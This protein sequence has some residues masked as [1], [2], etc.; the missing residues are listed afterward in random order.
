MKVLSLT[1]VQECE[2][3]V[4]SLTRYY[5]TVRLGLQAA[6]RH[7]PVNQVEPL[8]E[9]TGAAGVIVFG[10]AWGMCGRFNDQLAAY[11]AEQLG[12]EALAPRRLLALGEYIGE[13]LAAHDRPADSQRPVPESVAGITAQVRNLLVIIE[14]W[15]AVQGIDRIILFYNE[16][17]SGVGFG[18]QMHRLLPLD[19]EW[20]DQLEAKP[21]PTRVLPAFRT[22]WDVLFAA[23]VRQYLFVSLYRA[24]A[25]SLASEHSSR[26]AAMQAAEENVDERLHELQAEFHRVRQTAITEELLD[27]TSGFEAL[28]SITS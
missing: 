25:E 23:L 9:S 18:P 13:T 24:F 2:Q 27:I 3:A 28:R 4:A 5:R 19:R 16:S 17:T 22:E 20:L 12:K 1:S 21:W 10:S 7:R 26:L 6:L 15:R 8:L 11:L 14:E